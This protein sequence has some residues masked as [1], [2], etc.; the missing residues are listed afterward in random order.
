VPPAPP[1]HT[2]YR[3][4]RPGRGRQ[5]AEEEAGR[6]RRKSRIACIDVGGGTTDLMI[7]SYIT[8]GIDDY[9]TARSCIKTASRRG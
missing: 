1:R 2:A 9:I 5:A 4:A 6:E 7:A 3:P 8:G